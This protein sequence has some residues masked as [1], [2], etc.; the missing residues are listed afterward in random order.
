[1]T[2]SVISDGLLT[3]IADAIREK[4][5]S[6]DSLTPAQM[7]EAIA[8][9]PAGGGATEPYMETTIGSNN[10][11]SDVALYGYTWIPQYLLYMMSEITKLEMVKCPFT[12]VGREAFSYAGADGKNRI[13]FVLPDT[14]TSVDVKAFSHCHFDFPEGLPDSITSIYQGSFEYSNVA[15]DH[16]PAGM[17]SIASEVFRGCESIT[18]MTIHNGITSIGESAF[19]GCKNL[20]SITIPDSVT[21]F[22]ANVF[23]ETGL[24]SF[25]FPSSITSVPQNF[26]QRNTG[27]TA[28]TIPAHITS[29]GN[30]A[31]YW[32]KTLE[33]VEILGAASLGYSAFNGCSNLKTV[34]IHDTC[35]FGNNVFYGCSALTDI[36]VPWSEGAVSGAP[37]GATAATIH[38]D[39]TYDSN[40]DPIT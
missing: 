6:T 11:V 31:F 13:Q 27:L 36:Y 10:K 28:L 18:S 35:S 20:K 4:T 9:I 17:N 26:L 29:I 12:M 30:Y 33:D 15:I 34:R 19:A 40:G 39:T 2:K 22:G 37:W 21:S 14:V 16:L 38:Y 24:E 23:S 32:I 5:G 25:N 1:M 8:E 7:A 3:A